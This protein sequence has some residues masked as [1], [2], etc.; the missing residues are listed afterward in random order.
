MV[1]LGV[2]CG[3]CFHSNEIIICPVEG[4][5]R[6]VP[7]QEQ[8]VDLCQKTCATCNDTHIL[9]LHLCHEVREVWSLGWLGG[10]D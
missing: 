6:G 7:G 1:P 10:Q 2:S 3:L 8:E 9:A 4:E 5:E